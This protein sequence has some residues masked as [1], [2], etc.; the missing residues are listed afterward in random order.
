MTLT[1]QPVPGI[2]LGPLRVFVCD[3][4]GCLEIWFANTL[5]SR[6][7]GLGKRR[8]E[9]LEDAKGTKSKFDALLV[10][11]RIRLLPQVFRCH[12]VITQ[13]SRASDFSSLFLPASNEREI[14]RR[15]LNN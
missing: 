3:D 11:A 5:G 1:S 7:R 13:D 8:N 9:L 10:P 14:A 4:L 2:Q 12:G 15:T 6:R